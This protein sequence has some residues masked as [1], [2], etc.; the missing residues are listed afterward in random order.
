MI[1]FHELA[2]NWRAISDINL[3]A[4]DDMEP[5]AI[6]CDVLHCCFIRCYWHVEDSIVRWSCTIWSFIIHEADFHPV[7]VVCT[8]WR[9]NTNGDIDELAHDAI[10]NPLGSICALSDLI[11]AEDVSGSGDDAAINV[12]EVV[13][14]GSVTY[15]MFDCF[16]ETRAFKNTSLHTEEA[17]KFA[18]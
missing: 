5:I 11:D 3:L 16:G 8:G 4:L 1:D 10:T 6:P 17:T 2:D 15:C 7:E 12:I 9:H 14:L 18:L 13:V